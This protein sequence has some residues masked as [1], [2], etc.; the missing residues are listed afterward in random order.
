MDLDQPEKRSLV[1]FAGGLG[2]SSI[3]VAAHDYISKCLGR[4]WKMTILATASL[5]EI[6]KAFRAPQFAGGIVTMP[7]KKTIIPFLDEVDDLVATS[8]ACNN[9]Y[10]TAE[11]KLR[12]T[13]TDWV[14]IK[15]ALLSADPLTVGECAMV[16]GAG[17]ASRAAVYALGP[18]LGYKH[19]YVVNRDDQ[20]VADLIEDTKNY[21]VSRPNIIHIRSVQQVQNL[22]LP[23]YIVSTIPDFPARTP[24]EINARA[25]LVHLLSRNTSKPGVLLDMCY[26]PLLTENLKLAT[27]YGWTPAEG[28]QVVGHQLKDQWK[29]WTGKEVSQD[30]EAI[31]WQL[32]LQAARNDPT[33][34]GEPEMM[35]DLHTLP[36]DSRP[37]RVVRNNGPEN[38]ILE[39]FKLR[40]L[41]E[42]WPMYR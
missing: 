12:G 27:Q 19:I 25:I 31:V 32:L 33:V 24:G 1:Y 38:L 20:E 28:V 26:H 36:A 39:R 35:V 16:Y 40:E 11:G 14:G 17:G 4:N 6:V 34:V 22:P 37:V 15:N 2:V 23:D 30:E 42:G 3:A 10:L 8:G 29:L 7:Y 13:N 9:V 5:D 18:G 41:A 21:A